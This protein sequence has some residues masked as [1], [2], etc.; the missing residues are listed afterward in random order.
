MQKKKSTF[1][2]NVPYPHNL[3]TLYVGHEG[4]PFCTDFIFYCLESAY[5]CGLLPGAVDPSPTSGWLWNL[6]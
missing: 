3:W 5:I 6:F 2:I 4:Y 1:K